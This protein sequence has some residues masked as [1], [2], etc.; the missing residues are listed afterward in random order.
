MAVITFNSGRGALKEVLKQLHLHCQRLF[1]SARMR[2]M[3]GKLSTKGKSLSKSGNVRCDWTGS[4][5]KRSSLQQRGSSMHQELFSL[6]THTFTCTKTLLLFHAICLTLLLFCL[7]FK[8]TPCPLAV[9]DITAF[10][11][12]CLLVTGSFQSHQ[13]S[14]DSPGPDLAESTRSCLLLLLQLHQKG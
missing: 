8:I 10:S 3:S 2:C 13:I 9:Q 1:S 12:P 11:K 14:K 4:P 7:Q 6:C 5:P